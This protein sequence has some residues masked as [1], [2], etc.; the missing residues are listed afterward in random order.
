MH[1]ARESTACAQ[2]FAHA[3]MCGGVSASGTRGMFYFVF[4][5]VTHFA[6]MRAC[7][8]VSLPLSTSHHHPLSLPRVLLSFACVFSPTG[9]VRSFV[10]LALFFSGFY[11][12]WC[13][14][15]VSK[16]SAICICGIFHCSTHVQVW[17]SYLCDDY[18]LLIPSSLHSATFLSISAGR[19]TRVASVHTLGDGA[20]SRIL[21]ESMVFMY[22]QADVKLAQYVESINGI[23]LSYNAFGVCARL[24]EI[25]RFSPYTKNE[26]RSF[27]NGDGVQL[28]PG[29]MCM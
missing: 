7:N 3:K 1:V 6:H 12:L 14:M 17:F 28:E 25:A 16:K 21:V 13:G 15:L 10:W 5:A 26:T 23:F 8:I 4:H 2:I 18:I 9:P 19:F 22:I 11:A 24:L 29:Q 20:L 27:A